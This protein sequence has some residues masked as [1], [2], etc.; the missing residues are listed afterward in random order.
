MSARISNTEPQNLMTSSSSSP[1]VLSDPKYGVA[2]QIFNGHPAARK[3]NHDWHGVARRI[4]DVLGYEQ[5][6]GADLNANQLSLL[7]S[8]ESLHSVRYLT[9]FIMYYGM[10]RS[11]KEIGRS[12][13][14]S[15]PHSIQNNISKINCLFKVNSTLANDIENSICK[16]REQ[17]LPDAPNNFESFVNQYAQNQQEVPLSLE[18]QDFDGE[19]WEWVDEEQ[20]SGRI[21]TLIP[22]VAMSEDSITS[23]SRT[24][25]VVSN[26]SKYDF[27][28][29][30]LDALGH[31][32]TQQHLTKEEVDK[33]PSEKMYG[34][35][36][37]I[38]YLENY[39]LGSP[40]NEI[41]K[42][43]GL[44][45]TRHAMHIVSTGLYNKFKND[46][47]LL[48]KII[49]YI[50]NSAHYNSLVYPGPKIAAGQILDALGYSEEQGDL[51][52]KQHEYL[53]SLSSLCNVRYL[54]SFIIHYGMGKSY[55]EIQRIY[56]MHIAHTFETGIS[57]INCMFKKNPK[58]VDQVINSI[59]EK[60]GLPIPD[61]LLD[62]DSYI[63]QCAL[64]LPEGVPLPLEIYDVNDEWVKEMSEVQMDE[65]QGSRKRKLEFL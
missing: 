41:Q 61:K 7:G 58:L 51:N 24:P 32:M 56:D 15:K 39:G 23:S 25:E 50:K 30:I 63:N 19:I 64:A 26:R 45:L 28:K 22:N 18:I 47:N 10:K 59:Y 60:R 48:G 53:S 14:T 55:K 38:I 46:D 2:Q 57:G 42:Q 65:T 16:I 8:I 31:S 5:E 11:L 35:R 3:K 54:P 40:L 12:N 20:G 44:E 36:N 33:L 1:A 52:E 37:L 27:A 21:S 43:Y 49:T 62:F 6:Q 17:P 29:Q 9:F 13:S 34:R 4:L